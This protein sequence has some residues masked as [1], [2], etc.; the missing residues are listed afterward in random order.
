MITEDIIALYSFFS[1]LDVHWIV[2]M[3]NKKWY[4]LQ[5][6]SMK[7]YPHNT[8]NTSNE[9]KRNCW[10]F[11][12]NLIL[13]LHKYFWHSLRV[14]PNFSQ[15]ERAG[16][17]KYP[18]AR[19]CKDISTLFACA[20]SIWEKLGTTRS[21]FLTCY[22]RGGPFNFWGGGWVL[23]KKNILQTLVRKKVCAQPLQKN[24][25]LQGTTW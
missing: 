23:L 16:A 22:W 13:S 8:G 7:Q 18:R 2:C 19:R 3:A 6:F 21:L 11:P 17:W 4:L 9:F 15:I 10:T 25:F 24:F 20:R 12:E 5:L 1:S 14:V